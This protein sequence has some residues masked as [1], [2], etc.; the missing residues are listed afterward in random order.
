MICVFW[1]FPQGPTLVTKQAGGEKHRLA[2]EDWTETG[3]WSSTCCC[4]HFTWRNQPV[5]LNLQG[6]LGKNERNKQ[7]KC[8]SLSVG[9]PTLSYADIKVPITIKMCLLLYLFVITLN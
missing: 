9:I 8:I 4:A 3:L 1:L 6:Y 5:Q 7:T 2:N